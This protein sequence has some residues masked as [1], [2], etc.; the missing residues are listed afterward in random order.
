MEENKNLLIHIQSWEHYARLF[1]VKLINEREL[2]WCNLMAMLM[3]SCSVMKG[4]RNGV[5]TK[6]ESVAPALIGTDGDLC[7]HIPNVCKKISKEL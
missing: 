7:H 5:E 6:H 2:F 1:I 3:D 4:S